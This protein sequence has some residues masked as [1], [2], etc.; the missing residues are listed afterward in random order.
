MKEFIYF[1]LEIK[2]S[3]KGGDPAEAIITTKLNQNC[4]HG[5]IKS[6]HE[7]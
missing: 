3:G 5:L 1:D 4:S 2:E 6:E 7:G